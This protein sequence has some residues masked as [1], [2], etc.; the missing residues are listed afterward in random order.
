M[1]VIIADD[2]PLARSLLR[3]LL[4][5]L[6]GITIL[7]ELGDGTGAVRAAREH[8]PDV[9]FLD[10]DMPQRN[11][12]LAALDVAA[13]GTEIVFVTAHEEHAI[14]A[15]ELGAVDYVLK[16]VRRVRLA[17]AVERARR[18]CAA[19]ETPPVRPHEASAASAEESCFWIT[20][21]K[22]IS[23]V[24]FEDIERIE[25]AR[26]HVYLHTK[27]RTYLHRITMNEVEEALAGS[28]LI[29]VHR[30]AF[31]RPD[32]VTELRRNRKMLLLLLKDGAT[33]PVGPSYRARTLAALGR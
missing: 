3:T 31:V 16:P 2:E 24:A 26:D 22:G 15:F 8:N 29:R 23:R 30:S 5:E 28:G 12:I 25:A 20:G 7:A 32:R 14:D 1:K 6:G 27:D 9:L 11:G 33:V 21:L 19:R 10:I 18:R 4:E 13:Q 17:L